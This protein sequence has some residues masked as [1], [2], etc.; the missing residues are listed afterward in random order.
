MAGKGAGRVILYVEAENEPAVR[1]YR[2]LG[3]AIVEEHAVWS[4]G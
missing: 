4:Q 1:V 2:N 3:F